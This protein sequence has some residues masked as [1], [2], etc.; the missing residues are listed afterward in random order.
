MTATSLT[1]RLAQKQLSSIRR[2]LDAHYGAT[3]ELQRRYQRATG[4]KVAR[5]SFTRWLSTDL[6]TCQQP[7]LGTYLLL[8]KLVAKMKRTRHQ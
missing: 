6:A 3:V 5:S 2:Y 4:E 1:R 7:A 8:E